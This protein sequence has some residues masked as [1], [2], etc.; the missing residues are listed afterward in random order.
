MK[1][2]DILLIAVIGLVAY[3][4]L[5][6]K[7]KPLKKE[8][9]PA[10]SGGSKA[11]LLRGSGAPQA[12]RNPS[13]ALKSPLTV[14]D[15]SLQIKPAFATR[16]YV[17]P[18]IEKPALRQPIEIQALNVIPSV[19]DREVNQPLPN[20]DQHYASFAGQCSEDIQT[21]CKCAS[22]KKEKFEIDIP[23]LP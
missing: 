17:M 3:Y 1:S 4:L 7:K 18:Q 23:K 11:P 9:L 13:P 16:D 14:Q 19:Y 2:R 8:D 6:G 21:A 22:T 5:M 20:K 10:G 12:P 15:F